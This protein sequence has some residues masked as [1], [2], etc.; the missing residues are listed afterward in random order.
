MSSAEMMKTIFTR[1]N[2]I[3]WQI[4]NS[5]LNM[6]KNTC[7]K[8]VIM[9]EVYNCMWWYITV[10]Y[11]NVAAGYTAYFVLDSPRA[12]MRTSRTFKRKLKR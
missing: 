8:R 10:K 4:K 6:N 11:L 5:I 7:T 9:N 1:A 2:K 12:S 3:I